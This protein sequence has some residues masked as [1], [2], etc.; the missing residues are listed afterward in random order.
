MAEIDELLLMSGADVPYISAQLQIHQPTIR[1]IS[2]VGE[3][4]FF[5]GAGLLEFDKDTLAIEDNSVLEKA[6][7]FDIMMMMITNPNPETQVMKLNMIMV[8]AI[9]FP[10]YNIDI[11]KDKI[12]LKKM[13]DDEEGSAVKEINNSN[14]EELR[15]SLSQILCLDSGHNGKKKLNPQSKMA[16]R[17]A[18]KLK[19]GRKKAEKTKGENTTSFLARQIAI[20]AVG[21]Q[22]DINQLMNYTLYQLFEEYQRYIAKIQY[23]MNIQMRMAGAKDVSAPQN[24]MDDLKKDTSA[25]F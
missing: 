17:I 24:W 7:N 8:L 20:L 25:S 10:D 6:S 5:A 16:K 14:Y 21:E 4:R 11:E 18:D 15:D 19:K 2:V 3:K 1:D 22:K 13:P 23:D 9:L 12:V